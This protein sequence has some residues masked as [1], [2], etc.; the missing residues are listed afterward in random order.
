MLLLMA[1]Q[2][3]DSYT[4]YRRNVLYCIVFCVIYYILLWVFIIATTAILY[5]TKKSDS[6]LTKHIVE[7]Q[8]DALYEETKYNKSYTY[9]TGVG[10]VITRPGYIFTYISQYTSHPI[11]DRA[12][13]SKEEKNNF[14]MMLKSKLQAR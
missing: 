14:L 10:K 5:Y 1:L 7:I 11:P 9:W 13:A 4:L 12:F 2:F 6:F 8:E 3:W